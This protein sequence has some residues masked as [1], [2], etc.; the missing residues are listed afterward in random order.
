MRELGHVPI[1]SLRDGADRFMALLGPELPV[2]ASGT[3][4]LSEPLPVRPAPPV[5]LKPEPVAPMASAAPVEATW[6]TPGSEPPIAA[7]AP[8]AVHRPSSSPP[9][10]RPTKLRLPAIAAIAFVAV[11][12]FGAF[13]GLLL[14]QAM[15]P[16]SHAEPAVTHTASAV[17]IVDS[18]TPASAS[19]PNHEPGDR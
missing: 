16:R 1:L 15:A 14:T 2:L 12:W 11:L 8:P 5:I 13:V 18:A 19:A 7:S 17:D 6:V 9:P 3:S 10:A 4:L